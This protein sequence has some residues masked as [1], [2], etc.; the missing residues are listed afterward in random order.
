M[1]TYCIEVEVNG[2]NKSFSQKFYGTSY[3]RLKKSLIQEVRGQCLL[4]KLSGEVTIE[5]TFIS[6]GKYLD[7]DICRAVVSDD[8]RIIEVIE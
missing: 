1:T 6:E 2:K 7:S 5:S 3:A 4:E 8:Y